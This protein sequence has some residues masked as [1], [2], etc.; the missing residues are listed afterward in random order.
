MLRS[1]GAA[2]AEPLIAALEAAEPSLSIRMNTLKG[3]SPDKNADSVP[4]CGAGVYLARRPVFAADPAWHQGCYYV[5]DA[6]SMAYSHA[7][8]TVV[9]RYFA[10]MPGLRYLDACAAPGGK[11]GTAAEALP[12][13]ALVVANELDPWRAA[14]LVEN[15]ARLGAPGVAV[16]RADASAIASSGGTFHIIAV[17]APCSGEGMMRKEPEAVAQWSPE[18]IESCAATQLRIVSDL[19]EALEPGGVMLYSTCTFNTRENEDTLRH[20]TDILGGEPVDLGLDAFEGVWGGIGTTLPCYRFA[21]GHVRGEGLFLAAVRKPL[22]APAPR[23]AKGRKG[24]DRV[25]MPKPDKAAADFVARHVKAPEMPLD[26]TAD[27]D[28]TVSV[29]PAAHAAFIDALAAKVTMLRR[30][31]PVAV[32]KG[33]ELAP[34]HTLALSTVIDP[35]SFATLE[36]D[37]DDALGFLH[38]DSLASLPEGLPRG[39]VLVTFDRRPLGFVK[40][41]GNRANNLVPDAFRLRIAPQNLRL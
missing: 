21:P 11:T 31:I 23:A 6:S 36:L 2:Y 16:T 25:A 35:A 14:V 38:G 40:N 41:I 34:A 9:D 19:W 28:G 22:D 12:P 18:L 24:R 13:D 33:R 4:W 7:V 27:A 8:R 30:G 29:R 3:C 5:Q 10:G 17:D 37:R 32:P 39:Y 20:L 26:I 15:M 1:Y